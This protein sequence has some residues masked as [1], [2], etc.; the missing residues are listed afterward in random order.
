MTDRYKSVLTS[1]WVYLLYGL[2][3]GILVILGIRF[4][5]YKAPAE[6]HYHANFAVFIN[7]KQENFKNPQFYEEVKVCSLHGSTPQARVHMHDETPGVIHVHD[8]AVT[9]GQFFENLGWVIGPDFIRTT[10]T[11]YTADDT[12]KLNLVL[13]G[14][15]LTGLT[16]ITD[17]VIQDRDRLL[18]SFGPSDQPALDSEYK[19][20]PNNAGHF[21]TTKDP[22]SCQGAE[23]TTTSDR[24]KHLF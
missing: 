20:V 19:I 16:S 12:N 24:L 14:Q 13:N 6:T 7:G 17:Q 11:L 15:N 4:I 18:V 21:D 2:L 5:T 10:D 3:V 22:A 1:K 8:E 23:T 9:W